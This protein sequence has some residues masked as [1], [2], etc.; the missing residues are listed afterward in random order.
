MLLRLMDCT[1]TTL[2]DI[3]IQLMVSSWDRQIT[4][5]VDIWEE[6]QLTIWPDGTTNVGFFFCLINSRR[7]R[8][9]VHLPKKCT[10]PESSNGP[11]LDW[12]Y[13]LCV[14]PNKLGIIGCIIPVI[15]AIL[16]GYYWTDEH[17]K[18]ATPPFLVSI[19]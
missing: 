10:S 4:Y 14:D 15:N 12:V 17:V 7:F 18:A 16:L 2:S 13:F 19:L 1:P 5:C 6:T 11:L 3:G 9:T 8:R